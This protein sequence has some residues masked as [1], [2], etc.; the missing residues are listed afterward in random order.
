[1]SAFNDY[2]HEVFQSLGP[3]QIRPMFGGYGVFHQGL[4]FAL[5]ADENLYLKTSPASRGLFEAEGLQPFVYT[6]GRRPIKM[7]YFQAPATIYEDSDEAL[8]WGRLAYQ[9]ALENTPARSNGR[10]RKNEVQ[11]EQLGTRT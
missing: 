2:L 9:A 4:M 1:M 10:Q 5:I 6:L 3:I 8:Y 7:G 11:L